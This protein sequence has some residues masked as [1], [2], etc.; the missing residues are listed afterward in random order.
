M[1]VNW[2]G[3]GMKGI[4]VMGTQK[5]V[6]LAP[7]WNEVD[8]TD[9]GQARQLVLVQIANE[10]IEEEFQPV[11]RG[12]KLHKT[13]KFFIPAELEKD[14]AT[15]VRVPVPI[16]GINGIRA[17]NIVEKAYNPSTLRKWLEEETRDTVRVVLFK[18]IEGVDNGSIKGD[19]KR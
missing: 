3:N 15:T 7:G 19:N 6:S 2:N 17:K 13:A 16:S 12:G 9:W 4:P 10:D 5:F 1:I 8:D 14:Q 11:E 18:Q